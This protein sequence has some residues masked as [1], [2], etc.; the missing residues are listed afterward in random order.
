MP[1]LY[2]A[3]AFILGHTAAVVVAVHAAFY[4]G[5]NS[6]NDFGIGGDML[7]ALQNGL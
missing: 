3:L 6:G 7:P 2:A 5:I 4:Q 1:D